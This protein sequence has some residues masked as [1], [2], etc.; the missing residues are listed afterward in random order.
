MSPKIVLHDYRFDAILLAI[1]SSL[2]R[3][4]PI[5]KVLLSYKFRDCRTYD[6]FGWTSGLRSLPLLVAIPDSCQTD[7]RGTHAEKKGP[8]YDATWKRLQDEKQGW[9]NPGNGR[10][11]DPANADVPVDRELTR[12]YYSRAQQAEPSASTLVLKG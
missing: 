6:V 2:D 8:L 9:G 5:A 11:L 10:V 12:T 1:D 3:V 7:D 4:E